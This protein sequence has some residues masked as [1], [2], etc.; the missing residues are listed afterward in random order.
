MLP[1]DASRFPE[2]IVISGSLAIPRP[3]GTIVYDGGGLWISTNDAVPAYNLIGGG[4]GAG[5]VIVQDEGVLVDATASVLDFTGTGVTAT[6]GAGTATIDIPGL[7]TQEEGVAVETATITLNF[8]GAGVTATSAAPGVVDVTI[9]GGG[10]GGGTLQDAYDQPGGQTIDVSAAKGALQFFSTSNDGAFIVGN[11]TDLSVT[12]DTGTQDYS[13]TSANSHVIA[14]GVADISAGSFV[15]ASSTGVFVRDASY[16]TAGPANA[17]LDIRGDVAWRFG[18][19]VALAGVASNVDFAPA[20][21]ASIVPITVA[22]NTALTGIAG[23]V[24]GRMLLLIN[25]SA[26]PLVIRDSDPASIAA[27]Q[28]RTPGQTGSI[29]LAAYSSILLVYSGV[30]FASKWVIVDNKPGSLTILPSTTLDA[31]T[32]Y[33]YSSF[34]LAANTAIPA[35][36]PGFDGRIIFIANTVGVAITVTPPSGIAFARSLSPGGGSTWMWYGA[37]WLCV[38]WC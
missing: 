13:Q 23:G 9:P 38:G 31:T 14:S 4:G 19:T 16:A 22:L 28:I 36:A 37:A 8:V 17:T 12:V 30:G 27:N 29:S 20:G 15:E 7:E 5:T 2:G 1:Y 26:S 10:G 35:L 32:V 11:G 3:V 34:A 24:N 18:T 25:T 6:G 21:P 33:Q